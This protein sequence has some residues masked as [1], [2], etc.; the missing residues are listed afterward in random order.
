M[1]VSRE[2]AEQEVTQWLDEKKVFQSTR[3]AY[4][5]SIDLLVDAIC[6]G[7]LKYDGD[8]KKFI[9][10]L[11]FPLGG[12]IPITELIY[13]QRLTDKELRPNL[14]GVKQGDG[15]GRLNAYVAA[16]TST[17]K[18]IVANLDSADK[19]IAMAISI[20]FL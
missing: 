16:L 11:L 20:F 8:K 7:V 15:D 13:K 18:E 2:L 17:N 4:K 6:E 10:T 12:E 3:E 14:N 19:K 5:D 9:H 1:K